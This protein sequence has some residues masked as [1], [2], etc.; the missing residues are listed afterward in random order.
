MSLVSE[1][2][3]DA[4]IPWFSRLLVYP[5]RGSNEGDYI[6]VEAWG[7]EGKRLPL[8]TAKTFSG[9]DK[10]WEYSRKLADILD[11]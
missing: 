1:A 9:R 10:A 11:V 6:H 2:G 7:R 8:F 3:S 4:P 5:V